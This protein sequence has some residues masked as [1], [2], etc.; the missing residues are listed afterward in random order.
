[1]RRAEDRIR[2]LG[3]DLCVSQDDGEQRQI[4]YKLRITLHEYVEGLRA[5]LAT[6]PSVTE[7]RVRRADDRRATK[8]TA[9]S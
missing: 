2:K 7:R 6:Y 5:H 1:M 3:A 9:R 4:L 8:G